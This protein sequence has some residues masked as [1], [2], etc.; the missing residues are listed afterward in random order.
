MRYPKNVWRLEFHY[1]PISKIISR[2]YKSIENCK[3]IAEQHLS[4]DSAKM[5]MFHKS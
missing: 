5:D 1:V 4:S 2:Y 3:T